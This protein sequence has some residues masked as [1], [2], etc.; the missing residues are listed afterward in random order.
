MVVPFVNQKMDNYPMKE[1]R[2]EVAYN[3]REVILSN[4]NLLEQIRL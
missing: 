1:V 4:F 3:L 2:Q